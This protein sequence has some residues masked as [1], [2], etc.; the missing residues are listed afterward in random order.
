MYQAAQAIMMLQDLYG[1]IPRVSGKGLAAKHVWDLLK[2][3]SLEPRTPKKHITHS[4]ID[5]LLLL[6]R[7]IDLVSPLV[8]QLTYEGLIDEL[9]QINRCKSI[10]AF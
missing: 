1:V 7:S 8:T 2:R 3:L 10:F 6:D 4:Q 5:H 9:F